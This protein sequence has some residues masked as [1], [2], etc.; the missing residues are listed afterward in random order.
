M[1][2][3][4]TENKLKNGA[5]G[6]LIHVPNA[7]V[8]S[9]EINFRAGDFMAPPKKW[10]VAHI[11]EHL[12]LGANELIPRARSFQAEFEKNGAYSNA[13]T[14]SYDITYEAE[15]ADFEWDRIAELLLVAISK[16]LFLEDEF[17]AEFGNVR[18][19]MVGRS[20]NHFR[21][22]S[23]ALREAYGYKVLTDQERLKRMKNVTVEDVKKHYAKT[24]MT[25]N[26][27]FVIAGKLTAPRQAKVLEM[28]ENIGLPRGEKRFALPDEKPAGL[29][30]PL[31]IPNRTVD[32]LH[33]YLDTFLSRRLDE[34]ESDALGLV[35]TLLTETLHSR[36]LGEARERGLVYGMSS[37]YLQTKKASNWWFGTQVTPLN[38][39]ALF[40]IIARELEAVKNAEISASD[41]ASAKQ[42]LL[43]RFQRSGQTV[44]GVAAGYSARYFFDDYIDDYYAIPERI[45]AVTKERIVDVVGAFFDRPQ[46]GIGFLGNAPIELRE[47]LVTI[48]TPLWRKD[49]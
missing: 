29:K 11:M 34:D 5:R 8:M 3:T 41:I 6:L 25:A 47:Q 48:L 20:N 15:C 17:K 21:H 35:N 1:K 19:E 30:E 2:H 31:H 38:A 46:W 9:L 16:P 36:I 44:S 23:L 40:M 43:G 42:Y 32:N 10:E 27:R 26:M 39:P 18:E 33:F 37:N 22:L 13:S 14:G 24:H 4:V 49:P 7:S 45:R 12:L 28:L